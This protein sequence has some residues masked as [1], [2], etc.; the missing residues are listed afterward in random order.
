[1]TAKKSKPELNQ[2]PAQPVSPAIQTPKQFTEYARLQE[3][4]AQAESEATQNLER[5]TKLRRDLSNAIDILAADSIQAELQTLESKQAQLDR[6]R[7]MARAILLRRGVELV[8]QG[9]AE[10]NASV[11][12]KYQP[13]AR[14]ADAGIIE[15]ATVLLEKLAERQELQHAIQLEV[16]KAPRLQGD[17]ERRTCSGIPDRAAAVQHYGIVLRGLE[18]DFRLGWAPTDMET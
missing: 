17:N 13:Q 2:A 9:N 12:A 10:L 18:A 14:A 16:D 5:I 7:D 1:M 15:A 11:T 6:R 8:T 4:A 3:D